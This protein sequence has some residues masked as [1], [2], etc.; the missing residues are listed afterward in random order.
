MRN[1]SVKFWT[2]CLAVCGVM[3]CGV[4]LFAQRTAPPPAPPGQ[5]IPFSHKAHAGDLKLACK[6]CHK[7]PDPGEMMGFVSPPVC[8][9]CHS[10]IK[11]DSPA[12]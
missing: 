8:M 2:H 5:P 9:Q 6:M 3:A 7:S 1:T 4:A 12:L 10:T 11:A